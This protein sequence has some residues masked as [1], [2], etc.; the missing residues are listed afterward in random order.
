[1]KEE[2]LPVWN[3]KQTYEFVIFH[4]FKGDLPPIKRGVIL[5]WGCS[6]GGSTRELARHYSDSQI[7]GIDLNQERLNWIPREPNIKLIRCDGYNLPFD[8]EHFDAIF[9]MNNLWWLLDDKQLNLSDKM[10]RKILSRIT[11]FVKQGGY[12]SVGHGGMEGLSGHSTFKREERRFSLFSHSRPTKI[13]D[14]CLD[15]LERL[16]QEELLEDGQ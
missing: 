14:S 6:Y 8:K 15:R 4:A 3:S 16:M 13:D 7:L 9:C 12:F 5:D 10:I 1:M 11:P 2:R